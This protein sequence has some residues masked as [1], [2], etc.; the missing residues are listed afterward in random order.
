MV[1]Q[2][3]I[4]AGAADAAPERAFSLPEFD[5]EFLDANYPGWQTIRDGA[6]PWLILNNFPIPEGYSHRQVQAAILIPSGHPNAPLDMVYFFPALSRTSGRPIAAL[7][8]QPIAGK[9]WQRWS[10][11]YRW[12]PGIDDLVTHTERIKAWLGEQLSR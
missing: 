2:S 11:H 8:S 3:T 1:I 12:R 9:L 6:T 10:R 7:A 5:E 4:Q